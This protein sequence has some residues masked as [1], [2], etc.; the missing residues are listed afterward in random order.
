MIQ[1][2]QSIFLVLASALSAVLMLLPFA[3]A[4]ADLGIVYLDLMPLKK[5]L[6]VKAFIVAPQ[7]LNVLVGAFAFY[8]LLLFKNRKK[9]MAF[10]FVT[11][12]AALVLFASLFFIDYVV[13][14]EGKM[15]TMNYTWVAFIPMMQ[16]ALVF[17]ARIFINKDEQL[18]RSADRLR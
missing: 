14:L 12:F 1:R 3:S 16:F 10:C 4:T 7:L 17:L 9:Q 11:A 13:V 5:V 18:V 15:S 6:N 8:T 2:V